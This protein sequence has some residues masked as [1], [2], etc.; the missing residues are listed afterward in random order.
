MA[1]IYQFPL[2]QPLYRVPLDFMRAAE[3]FEMMA[4]MRSP[5]DRVDYLEWQED[6]GK[7]TEA[8]A[9]VLGQIFGLWRGA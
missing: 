7:L 3:S 9:Y 1:T 6:R 4:C 2:Q 8:E 5:E